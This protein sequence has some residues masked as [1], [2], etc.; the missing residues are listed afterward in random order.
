MVCAAAY[1]IAALFFAARQACAPERRTISLL[2][3][4]ADADWPIRLRGDRVQIMVEHMKHY[5]GSMRSDSFGS[6]IAQ[7]GGNGPR[8]RLD[9]STDVLGGNHLPRRSWRPEDHADAR[10]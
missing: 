3:Q 9:A 2:Q 1:F 8:I 6:V 7:Q 4:L 5:A 10:G